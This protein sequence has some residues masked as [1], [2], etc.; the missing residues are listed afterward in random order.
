MKTRRSFL[1]RLTAGTFLAALPLD[2][3]N[4]ATKKKHYSG[5]LIHHVYFWLKNPENE[6]DRKQ[7]EE[8]I[9]KLTSIDVIRNAHFGV[10]ASTE[11]REVVDHS[12]TY[13][14][15]LIFDGKED[16]DIYQAHPKH[17]EF[18]DKN[19]HLWEKVIVYDSV[20]A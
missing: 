9:N 14:L 2:G 1:K 5:I 17:K 10:P 19:Q 16:Q 7:F 4:A 20:D 3:V 11:E 13:S 6:A 18:V 12:Y 15:M 8:A